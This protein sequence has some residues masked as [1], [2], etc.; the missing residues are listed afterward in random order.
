MSIPPP[1]C[2]YNPAPGT[3]FFD[4]IR[5]R[6]L[7]FGLKKNGRKVLFCFVKFNLIT[8]SVHYKSLSIVYLTP[9]PSTL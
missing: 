2:V 5:S 8:N 4:V 7:T 9:H 6:V 1:K 3:I